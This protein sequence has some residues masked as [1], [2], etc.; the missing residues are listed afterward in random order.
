MPLRFTGTARATTAAADIEAA[1]IFTNTYSVDFDGINDYMLVSDSDDFSFGDAS[2]DNPFTITAWIKMDDATRFRIA[3][4]EQSTTVIEW[5]FTVSAADKLGL[6]LYD[7]ADN[8]REGVFSNSTL[9]SYEGTWTHVAAIYDGGGGST[10][11][12]GI[13]LYLNG[14]VLA[15]TTSDVTTGGTY[16]AMHNTAADV[17]IG[18]VEDPAVVDRFSDGKIDEVAIFSTEL[19]ASDILAIYNSGTPADLSSYSPVGWWRMGDND[20]GA[21]TNIT[22]QGSGGNNATLVNGPVISTDVP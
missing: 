10:A 3:A 14:A 4:K 7:G 11:S 22:D 16:T 21:G 17:W 1:S 8:V 13:T 19:S 12:D 18:A 6:L 15:S 20:G 9:T 2:T 5:F